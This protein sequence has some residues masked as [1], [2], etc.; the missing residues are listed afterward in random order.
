M[1]AIQTDVYLWTTASI[2]LIALSFPSG[3]WIE[4]REIVSSVI[5]MRLDACK[6]VCMHKHILQEKKTS[7]G[8]WSI[9][10]N[11]LSL[12]GHIIEWRTKYA[13]RTFID[14]DIEWRIIIY[15]KFK[16]SD[17]QI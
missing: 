9:T 12:I 6:N 5:S 2:Q 3:G 7:L 13:Q 16:W 17:F 8:V 11:V 4:A 10:R 15:L 1:D 14:T